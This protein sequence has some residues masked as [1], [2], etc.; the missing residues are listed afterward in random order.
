M[1]TGDI[2]RVDEVVWEIIEDSYLSETEVIAKYAPHFTPC[3]IT[4]AYQEISNMRAENESFL[5]DHPVVGMT[6]TREQ[7]HHLHTSQRGQLCLEVT[8]KC[9]FACTYCER[10]VPIA[11]VVPVHGTKDMP[12][13]IA[14]AAIDDFLTHCGISEPGNEDDEPSQAYELSAA[15]KNMH[16]VD[17]IVHISFYGG[18]PLLNFPLI[19][20]CCEYVREKTN[21]NKKLIFGITTNGYLLEGDI[22]EFMGAQKFSVTVSLDGPVSL[23]DQNRKTTQG[24]PTHHVVIENL[25]AFIRKYPAQLTSISAVVAPG[26]DPR[27]AH[28]YF[29]SAAWLPPMVGVR[30]S[31]AA[32][33]Y[34]GYFEIPGVEEFPGNR[35]MFEDFKDRL[36]RGRVHLDI[37]GRESELIRKKFSG[38]FTPLHKRRGRIAVLRQMSKPYNP[39]GACVMGVGRAIVSVTGAYFPCEKVSKSKMYQI[40]STATGMDEER[41]YNLLR[42]FIECTRLECEQCWCLAFCSIGCHATVY[43]L[44]GFSVDTKRRACEETRDSLRRSL[45]EYCSILEQNPRTFDYLNS[46]GVPV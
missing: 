25:R 44:D 31:L 43:D 16:I 29:A 36:I 1:N 10:N 37:P 23:H 46:R 13:E 7:I 35:A 21:G 39:S 41:V 33:P 22:A 27:E 3:Q 38:M 28:R 15:E 26:T 42:E 32:P 19:K 11:G 30:I 17:G 20:K 6:Y 2:L 45:V 40:G 8:E 18:E 9:N 34:P 12:W 4:K 14:R 24:A 5:N